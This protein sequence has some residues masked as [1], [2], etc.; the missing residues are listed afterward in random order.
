[1]ERCP[2]CKGTGYT[3]VEIATPCS[4]CRG[5]GQKHGRT[6]PVCHGRAKTE[7]QMHT[8][9]LECHALGV[10]TMIGAVASSSNKTAK[11]IGELGI[12]PLLPTMTELFQSFRRAVSGM[13]AA[14]TRF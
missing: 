9:C 4:A 3:T 10:M 6:C 11:P 7:L 2:S 12:R 8:R 13:T 1:M 5:S 14:I